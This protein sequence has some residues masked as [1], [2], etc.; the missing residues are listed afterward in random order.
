[1]ESDV[2]GRI[3]QVAE[4]RTFVLPQ[5][6]SPFRI[7]VKPRTNYVI[8]VDQTKRGRPA[9]LAPDLGLSPEDIRYNAD[10]KLLMARIHNVGSKAVRGV[11][12]AFYDGNPEEGGRLIGTQ[13]IPNIEAPNDLEP[14]TV[15]VGVN[16]A[17]EKPTDIYVVIDPDDKIPDEIT[18]FN[19]GA[20]KRLPEPD[21]AGEPAR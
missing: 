20:H 5:R 13:V 11:R 12:V 7:T 8:E 17:I 10:R 15:T 9:G 6:G 18:T 14:K 16:Y 21:D 2:D 4:K 1:I 3:D 19:N